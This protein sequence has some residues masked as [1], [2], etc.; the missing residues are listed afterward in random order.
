[1]VSVQEHPNRE[2]NWHILGRMQGMLRLSFGT[3][4]ARP[5]GDFE[6]NFD[7]AGKSI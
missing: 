2:Y 1:M 3:K 7:Q 6:E 5:D 4:R